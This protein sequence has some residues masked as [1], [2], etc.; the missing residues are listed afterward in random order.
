M[1]ALSCGDGAKLVG[2]REEVFAPQ[3][4]CSQLWGEAVPLDLGL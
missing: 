1:S 3:P 2:M 4:G